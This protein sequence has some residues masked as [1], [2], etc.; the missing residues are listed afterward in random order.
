M[1]ER[2]LKMRYIAKSFES[3]LPEDIHFCG[4]IFEIAKQ[5]I[6]SKKW[7]TQEYIKIK[8]KYNVQ[9]QKPPSTNKP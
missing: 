5:I 2:D 4:L 8:R 9:Y 6:V 3:N 1:N 7:F